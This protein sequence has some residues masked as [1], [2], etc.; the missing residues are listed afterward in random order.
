MFIQNF[1]KIN[2]KWY[3]SGHGALGHPKQAQ[4]WQVE[5]VPVMIDMKIDMAHVY[6]LFFKD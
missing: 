2:L 6:I 4:L 5:Q 1:S 3:K